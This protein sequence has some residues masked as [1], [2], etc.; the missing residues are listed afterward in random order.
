MANRPAD[1]IGQKAQQIVQD[2]LDS[3][4]ER[5]DKA[6][7]RTK[8]SVHELRNNAEDVIDQAFTRGKSV[9]QQ[10]Q[11]K[12]ERFVSSH[13][14]LVLGGVLLVGYILAGSRQ[15]GTTSR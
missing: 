2:E 5:V 14:W 15:R 6:I 4:E 8:D 12:V 11:E 9:W 7:E 13:P 3:V 1:E 10:Q